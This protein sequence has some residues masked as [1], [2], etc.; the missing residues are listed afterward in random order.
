VRGREIHAARA[1]LGRPRLVERE[2]CLEVAARALAVTLVDMGNPHCVVFVPGRR[3]R[4]GL[5]PRRG[6]RTPPA[7]PRTH[8]RVVRGTHR[9]APA[10]A[11]LERG[12][13]E[14]AACGTGV[15]ASAVTALVRGFLRSPVEVGTRG[16]RLQVDWNGAD[17]LLPHRPVEALR[18][19]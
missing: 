13:G 4:G 5:G 2:A 18:T 17:E 3:T 8:Q 19:K 14:T 12:V 11:H 16:G 15:G 6:D 1:E 10:R 7:L 9:R